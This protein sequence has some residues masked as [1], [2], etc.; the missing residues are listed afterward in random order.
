MGGGGAMAK[1]IAWDLT[2][3]PNVE[4]IVL[5]DIQ[6][7][8]ARDLAD[9]IKSN[10]ISIEKIDANDHESMVS[11]FKEADYV[12]NSAWYELN[13]PI[14]KACLEA[15]ISYA[16]LGGLYHVTLEQ[17]ELN[18]Q[19]K[20]SNLSALLGIGASPGMTNLCVSWAAETFDTIKEVHIRTGTAGGAKGFA[21]SA[22]TVID[23]VTME[24]AVY[25][26]KALDFVEP[27][28]GREKYN[29]PEPVGEVEGFYSIHSELATLPDF[30]DKIETVT[31]RVA[32]SSRLV[33]IVDSLLSLKLLSD[34]SVNINGIDIKAKDFILKYLARLPDP[35]YTDEY[36][37]FR[38]QV[39]GE[40]NGAVNEYNYETVVSSSPERQLRAT[41]IWTGVPLAVALDL[42]N[43]DVI[44]R[45]GVFPPEKGIPIKPFLE[46]L[47][48]RNIMINENKGKL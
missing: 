7:D 6:T 35:E 27:L 2:D 22:K 34:D 36:K 33:N 29:L 38:V 48:K 25:R 21:Y 47:S 41:S 40:K 46:E 19:F 31:F 13:V 9:I 18:E 15:E 24:P 1:A 26:D 37:S 4:Q 23:E 12:A 5:A 8:K 42:M 45:K 30:S 14:M 10:K 20:R 17:L 11:I 39:I 32:F 44:T 43:R 3:N 16:D 28:S